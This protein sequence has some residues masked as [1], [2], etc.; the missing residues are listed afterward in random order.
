MTIRR[1]RLHHRLHEAAVGIQILEV[2]AECQQSRRLLGAR[3]DIE[4]EAALAR[5]DDHSALRQRR[6][7]RGPGQSGHAQARPSARRCPAPGH[8]G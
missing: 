3:V 7:A 5:L 1:E 2:A 4:R 8:R 6:R